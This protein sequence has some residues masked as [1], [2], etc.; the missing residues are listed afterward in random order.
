MHRIIS[1]RM[2]AGILTGV[3]IS[4]SYAPLFAQSHDVQNRQRASNDV[5]IPCEPLSWDAANKLP[6]FI[7]AS[8]VECMSPTD[9]DLEASAQARNLLETA[10]VHMQNHRSTS[11]SSSET[12][13]NDGIAA[14]AEGRYIAAIDHFR[15]AVP[16]TSR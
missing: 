11:G 6:R 5:A 8:D 7:K 4:T 3:L 13:Y 15:A 2:A 16:G 9:A 10:V 1:R 12:E 14:Y